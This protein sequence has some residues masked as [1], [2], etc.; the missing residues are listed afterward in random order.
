LEGVEGPLHASGYPY[1]EKG[2]ILR[3]SSRDLFRSHGVEP[4]R[5]LE[6]P[7]EEEG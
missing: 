4:F 2:E 3:Q 6:E 7:A 5:V 1:I